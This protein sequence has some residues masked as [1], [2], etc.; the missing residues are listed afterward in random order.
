MKIRFAGTFGHAP[1]HYYYMTSSS[2]LR[3]LLTVVLAV[4]ALAVL[5]PA[6]RADGDPGSDVLVY[7]NLFVAADS[8]I[9][10]P[11]QVEL[12]NLLTAADKDGFQIRVAVIAT[13]SDLGAITALWQQPTAY[14]SF[15]GTE[16]SLA[17]GQRLLIVMPNGFGFNW[18]RHSGSAAY[19]V[20]GKLPIG[21]GGAGLATAAETAVRAL[22]Q[23]AG[24]RVRV[25]ASTT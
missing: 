25:P 23:A 12:G 5:S 8:N 21:S 3:A 2:L 15:L 16:L 1:F 14:A 18:Q 13:P 20:L 6:A 7:Q 22:A 9:S 24:I 19:S 10:V 4:V 17:Y 11:Q